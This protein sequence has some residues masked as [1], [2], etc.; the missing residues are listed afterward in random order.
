MGEGRLHGTLVQLYDDGHQTIFLRHGIADFDAALSPPRDDPLGPDAGAITVFQ[1]HRS[2]IRRKL[3]KA[4][5]RKGIRMKEFP[6]GNSKQE[7]NYRKW[8]L[9]NCLFLNPLNDLGNYSVAA[10]DI[11]TTPLDGR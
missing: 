7:I 9:G 11:L 3:P 2:W 8:C 6:V 1:K 5:L 10:N 4:E